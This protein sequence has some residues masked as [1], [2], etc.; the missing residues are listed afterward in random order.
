MVRRG[1]S[2]LEVMFSLGVIAVGLLGV[3]ALIPVGLSHVG[4][5]AIAD[6]ASRTGLD[7][8]EAFTARGM[9]RTDQWITRSGAAVPGTPRNGDR[10]AFCIDP[11]F[12]AVH[13]DTTAGASG[14]PDLFPYTSATS[15]DPR[16]LRIS[17]LQEPAGSAIMT[18]GQA[19]TVFV[20]A[21]DLVFDLPDDKSLA[22]IQQYGESQTRRQFDGNFSWL[23]T[24]V[25]VQDAT[26]AYRDLYTLSVVVFNDRDSSMTMDAVNERVANVTSFYS[27]GLAGGDV[28]LEASSAAA[29]DVKRGDWLMLMGIV[30]TGAASSASSDDTPLF[31]WYRILETE[32]APRLTSP[33]VWNLDVTLQ[34]PDWPDDVTTTAMLVR[35]VVSV[36][37]KTIRLEDQSMW[38]Y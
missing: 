29:L 5:G 4:K 37:E 20:T 12:A 34:G 17:L 31:R 25:P 16:M 33:A 32:S 3:M 2:L 30:A 19:E 35:N 14:N 21:D 1:V 22:P 28:A 6:S 38:S 8:V 27:S 15:S 13:F 36:Y 24:L 10:T 18:A 23:A 26:D 11:R 7:A 9:G